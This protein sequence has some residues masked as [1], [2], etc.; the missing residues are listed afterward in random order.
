MAMILSRSLRRGVRLIR[1]QGAIGGGGGVL[2][3][4]KWILSCMLGETIRSARWVGAEEEVGG[5]HKK[6]KSLLFWLGTCLGE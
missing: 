2:G 3:T 1:R 6:S 5:I 4:G